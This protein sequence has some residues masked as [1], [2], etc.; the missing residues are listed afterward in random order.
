MRPAQRSDAAGRP[1]VGQKFH[2][3]S[4]SDP[5]AGQFIVVRF[6]PQCGQNVMARPSGSSPSHDRQRSPALGTIEPVPGDEIPPDSRAM[7]AMAGG[8]FGVAPT[9]GAVCLIEIL[10]ALVGA[11]APAAGGGT[12]ADVGAVGADA[13]DAAAV[14]DVDGATLG[15]A[16]A[17]AGCSDVDEA[18]GI[19]MSGVPGSNAGPA[20]SDRS[21]AGE[22][23]TRTVANCLNADGSGLVA[24]SSPLRTSRMW[25]ST[26]R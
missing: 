3:S 1:Q 2:P 16:G 7:L 20:S 17:R 22:S 23:E 19:A 25:S 21:A 24:P 18:N 11:D 6:C 9:D 26:T 5:Q 13:V 4:S 14:V 15:A 10:G 8:V 12:V